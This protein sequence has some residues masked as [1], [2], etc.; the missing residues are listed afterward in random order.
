M[1]NRRIFITSIAI[2]ILI[3]FVVGI[4]TM[5]FM[6]YEIL[7]KPPLAPPNWLFPIVWTILYALMGVS[8]GI[9]QSKGK[10]DEEAKRIYWIQLGINVL[11]P[12]AFFVLRWRFF[13]FLW[14]IL[15]V[16]AIIQMIRMFT[17]R[18]SLAAKLQ[19]PYLI[20]TLFASYLNLG[21]YI[22]NR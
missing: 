3:G 16:L 21:T 2:P 9:L 15:L 20:W 11:W 19:I 4:I 13:A 10:L 14:I 12:I 6:D 18:D 8:Y 22:L 5:L 1:E 17:K 7:Q